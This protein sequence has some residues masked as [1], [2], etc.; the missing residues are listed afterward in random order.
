MQ[1]QCGQCYCG[2]DGGA[3]SR[4]PTVAWTAAPASPRPCSSGRAPAGPCKGREAPLNRQWLS[5][6]HPCLCGADQ[7]P[8]RHSRV[9][10]VGSGLRPAWAAEP[11]SWIQAEPII[12]PDPGPAAAGPLWTRPGATAPRRGRTRRSRAEGVSGVFILTREATGEATEVLANCL[13]HR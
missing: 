12:G 5:A 13:H 7:P 11:G 8:H 1:E 9:R 6:V 4:G 2:Q 10:V 3:A